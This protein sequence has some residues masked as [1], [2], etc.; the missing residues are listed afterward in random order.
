MSE[1]NDLRAKRKFGL[2]NAI[3]LKPLPRRRLTREDVSPKTPS[4]GKPGVT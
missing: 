4:S 3:Y 1:K 2:I